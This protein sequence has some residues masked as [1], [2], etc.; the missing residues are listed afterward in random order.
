[1]LCFLTP[2][3]AV[4]QTYNVGVL[5]SFHRLGFKSAQTQF[6]RTLMDAGLEVNYKYENAENDLETA[7]NL[8]QQFKSDGV[9]LI[10][11]IGTVATQAA[12][13]EAGDIPILYSA[14]PS[15]VKD[16]IIDS[17]NATGGNISGTIN[18]NPINKQ[19]DL[20]QEIYPNAK[21]WGTI[22]NPDDE[23]SAS[24]TETAKKALE[25]RGMIL[26]TATIH[27]IRSHQV[28]D[29]AVK[30]LDSDI[31]I[32]FLIRD[33]TANSSIS[34]VI[35]NC[36]DQQTPVVSGNIFAVPMGAAAA[37]GWKYIDIGENTAKKAEKVLRNKEAIKS[38]H[39]GDEL[40]HFTIFVSPKNAKKLSNASIPQKILTE[41]DRVF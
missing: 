12:I 4:M 2:T 40:D 37:L 16:G 34:A 20:F 15:P 5:M 38:M 33:K 3:M 7:R 25:S 8:I 13:L 39:A 19:I 18:A 26:K 21:V 23:L 27:S 1:M 32:M 22:Y 6:E 14:V 29:A 17:M 35:H 11:T 9:D 28:G 36:E 10:H 31:D 24:A 41:A 30:L